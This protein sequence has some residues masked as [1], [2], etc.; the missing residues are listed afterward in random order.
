MI[1]KCKVCSKNPPE[2]FQC[3]NESIKQWENCYRIKV[4]DIIIYF[5]GPY[6][7]TK[8]LGKQYE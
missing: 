6:C 8:Y 5:C 4:N 1:N 2:E 7:A 3:W